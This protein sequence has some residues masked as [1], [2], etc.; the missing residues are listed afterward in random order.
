MVRFFDNLS[1]QYKQGP[2][3]EENHYYPFGL[4]MAGISD[5][6]VK[7]QY[8][9]NKYRYNG[10]ELQHQEFSDGTGLEEYDYEARFQD[11]QLGV[12]HSIDPLADKSRKWSAYNYANDNPMRFIDPD[13]MD[14]S[15][16]LGDWNDRRQKEIEETSSHLGTTNSTAEQ[17]ANEA[18]ENAQAQASEFDDSESSDDEQNQQG[19]GTGT[20]R[21]DG[22]I[23]FTN[24]ASAYTWMFSVSKSNNNREELG[25]IMEK[26]VLVLP[27]NKNKKDETIPENY[28]Y[29]WN[30]GKLVDPVSRASLSILGTIHTH[31]DKSSGDPGP[32]IEDAEYFGQ[33]TP[34]KAFMTMGWDGV[35]HGDYSSYS[36]GSSAPTV[37]IIDSFL[38]PGGLS[39]TDLLNGY[40]LSGILSRM[41]LK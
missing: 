31:L 9:Q 22:S 6:A 39:I 25:A 13:G 34:Y 27:D 10:K 4:T 37:R 19:N 17:K 2:V 36:K 18:S 16:S 12:W 41:I 5:Q 28:G 15:E 24:Q 21:K 20:V 8:A 14:A 11:P 33:N 29:S 1:V 3:L 38:K 7:T 30:N 32:G 40:N 26:G 35:V 23:M